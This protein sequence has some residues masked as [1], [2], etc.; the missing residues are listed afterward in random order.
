MKILIDGYNLLHAIGFRGDLAAPGNLEQARLSMLEKLSRYLAPPEC[1]NLL[2]VFDA[3]RR[4][5][6]KPQQYVYRNIQ[7]EFAYDYEDADTMIESLIRKHSLPKS[8]LVVSSDHRIQNAAKRKK[9]RFVDSDRWIDQLEHPKQP[10][11]KRPNLSSKSTF[12]VDTDY[13]LRQFA[14]DEIDD[15]IEQSHGSLPID[16]RE[17]KEPRED[18]EKTIDTTFNPFPEGYGD[19][20]LDGSD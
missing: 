15:I 20:L 1:Q 7:V 8:L 2:V 9:A 11:Y 14:T 3:G 5:R 13:W 17:G 6:S 18:D 10:R 19:E 4:S 16:N 12:D